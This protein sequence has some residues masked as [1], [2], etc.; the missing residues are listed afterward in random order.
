MNPLKGTIAV[1]I[2]AL[3]CLA[4]TSCEKENAETKSTPDYYVTVGE[5]THECHIAAVAYPWGTSSWPRFVLSW[6]STITALTQ[7]WDYVGILLPPAWLN[8]DIDLTEVTSGGNYW[9]F[10]YYDYYGSSNFTV[11]SSNATQVAY[12]K[13]GSTMHIEKLEGDDSGE[14][15]IIDFDIK[16]DGNIFP[17]DI[18]KQFHDQIVTL[19][20]HYVGNVM[21]DTSWKYGWRTWDQYFGTYL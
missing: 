2:T 18:Y 11:T 8:Q 7:M 9:V 14:R 6:D 12:F 17:F 10:R 19:K 15:F 13:E 3:C 4:W 21:R 5:I 16:L 20:G 1:I